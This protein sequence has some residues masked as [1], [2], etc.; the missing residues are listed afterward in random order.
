MAGV[1]FGGGGGYKSSSHILWNC[2]VT[3]EVWKEA[4]FG[5][6]VLNQLTR[7]F[8]DVAWALKERKVDLDWDLFAI[9]VWLIWNNR[10]SF[11]YEGKCNDTK[12]IAKEACEFGQEVQEVQTSCPRGM[13]SVYNQWR[14]SK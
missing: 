5:L 8:M 10:N 14:S 12:R 9:M 11:K 3:V 2:K 7:D 13:A 4:K 6:F 1:A